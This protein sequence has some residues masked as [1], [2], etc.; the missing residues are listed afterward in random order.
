MGQKSW[1]T[2]VRLP[3]L[4][5]TQGASPT[6]FVQFFD[7]SCSPLF[8]SQCINSLL[9]LKHLHSPYPIL[10]PIRVA[11]FGLNTNLT[12]TMKLPLNA[13]SNWGLAWGSLVPIFSII[14]INT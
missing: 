13:S 5:V 7:S 9:C 12:S 11:P 3:S 10:I 6:N 4:A 1:V 8:V 2:T 14:T